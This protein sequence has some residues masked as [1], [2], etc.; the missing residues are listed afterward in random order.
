MKKP[1][2]NKKE[3]KEKEFIK[4]D[5]FSVDRVNTIGK[6]DSVVFDMTI[7]GV[8]IYGCFVIEGKDGDFIS[9]PSQKS[10]KNGKYYHHVY[11]ALSDKDMSDILAEVENKLN[12]K[13]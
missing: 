11:A 8:K 7:N 1:T 3:T 5:S 12:N 9:F 10:D 4:L 2:G 13:D 6:N